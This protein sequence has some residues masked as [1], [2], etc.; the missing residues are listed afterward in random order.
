MAE[1]GHGLDLSHPSAW[2]ELEN[3]ATPGWAGT[4]LSLVPALKNWAS[5]LLVKN[6]PRKTAGNVFYIKELIALTPPPP[7][8]TV[9]NL[10]TPGRTNLTVKRKSQWC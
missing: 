10:L 7:P 2:D 9:T 8:Y 6:S 3:R 1:G 4:A 5:L